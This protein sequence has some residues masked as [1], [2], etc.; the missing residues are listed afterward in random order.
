MIT[1]F[2]RING[3]HGLL[4]SSRQWR[5]VYDF[6]KFHFEKRPDSCVNE[7]CWGHETGNLPDTI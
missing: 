5:E 6:W 4:N 3:D 2:I 7:V 1:S